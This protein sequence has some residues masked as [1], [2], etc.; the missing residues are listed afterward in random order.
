LH[1]I[2]WLVSIY[3]TPALAVTLSQL[4]VAVSNALVKGD[5]FQIKPVHFRLASHPARKPAFY[6]NIQ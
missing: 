5:C 1:D 6:I 4:V 2:R 3:N